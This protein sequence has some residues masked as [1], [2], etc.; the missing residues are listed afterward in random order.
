M[1]CVLL[2]WNMNY[3]DKCVFLCENVPFLFSQEHIFFFFLRKSKYFAHGTICQGQNK[4]TTSK[5]LY[6]PDKLKT[7]IIFINLN[8]D[9]GPSHTR[10]L[11]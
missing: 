10:N 7:Q 6:E 8:M 3:F 5:I 4:N 1:K 9:S 11:H 2:I